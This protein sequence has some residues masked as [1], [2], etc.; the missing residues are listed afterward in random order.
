[1]MHEK[2]LEPKF[3]FSVCPPNEWLFFSYHDMSFS[4]KYSIPWVNIADIISQNCRYLTDCRYCSIGSIGNFFC[5]P[6]PILPILKKVPICRY[7]RYRY[8]YRPIPTQILLKRI[9]PREW[10]NQV[11]QILCVVSFHWIQVKCELT[12]IW[13]E[14]GLRQWNWELWCNAT[15]FPKR[16]A[17]LI[18]PFFLLILGHWPWPWV[19]SILSNGLRSNLQKTPFKNSRYFSHNFGMVVLP[20]SYQDHYVNDTWCQVHWYTLFPKRNATFKNLRFFWGRV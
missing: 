6:I 12:R 10:R 16:N 15:L 13:K 1:M 5:L 3:F 19:M 2:S 9:S 8:W 14:I 4:C 20:S 17:G 7:F 18:H 11:W